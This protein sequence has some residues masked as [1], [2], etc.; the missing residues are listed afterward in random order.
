MDT[1][2][3]TK[4]RIAGKYATREEELA[5]IAAAQAGDVAARNLLITSNMG[6]I[7]NLTFKAIGKDSRERIDDWLGLA[8][9]GWIRAIEKF[10]PIHGMRLSTYAG[11]WIFQKINA[12]RH[13]NR[14]VIHVPRTTLNKATCSDECRDAGERAYRTS[15]FTSDTP[16]PVAPRRSKAKPTP[17][18]SHSLSRRST[19]STRGGKTCCSPA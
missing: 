6:T 1:A 14:S 11:S 19:N 2:A 13:E 12:Y 9:E 18:C 10:D 4:P 16:E 15:R 8:V 17:N 3:A 5:L 7:A